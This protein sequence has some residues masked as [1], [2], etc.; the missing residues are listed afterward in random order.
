MAATAAAAAVIIR[1]WRT[2]D[3]LSSIS[4]ILEK[5]QSFS[6]CLNISFC[7]SRVFAAVLGVGGEGV[8]EVVEVV[9]GA[10]CLEKS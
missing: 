8:V 6:L 5:K 9:L 3:W 7:S 2:L 1:G 4:Q 10:V